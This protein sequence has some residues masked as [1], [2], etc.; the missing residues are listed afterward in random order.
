MKDLTFLKKGIFAYKG[1]YDNKNVYE[2]TLEAFKVA[3]KRRNN[4]Y[5]EVLETKDHVLVVCNN[6][7]FERLHN[8]KD[9]VEDMT[10][11]ELN[12][13]SFYHIPSLVE[14]LD[15]IDGKVSILIEP[16]VHTRHHILFDLLDN[17]KGKFAIISVNPRIINWFNKN[18]PNYIVGEVVTKRRGFNLGFYFNKT[19]FKSYNINYF[20]KIK[21]NGLKEVG[22]TVLGYLINSDDK[23]DTYKDIFDNLIVDNF[24]N[25]KNLK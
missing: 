17:Y 19:D 22:D 23:Y 18:R 13:V 7:V 15:L 2:N 4:I 5:L 8:S 20:D 10:Y 16:R 9:K 3:I 24:I 25:L 6:D 12:F 21:V 11:E 1:I 14:V